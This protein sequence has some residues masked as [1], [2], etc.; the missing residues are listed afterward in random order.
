MLFLGL[1]VLLMALKLAEIGPVADWSWWWILL[2][3]GLAV[4]WWS[5]AD[6][7][8]LTRRREMDKMEQRKQDRRDRDMSALGL[9]PRCEKNAARAAKSA[10]RDAEK[11]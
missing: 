9:T 6:S 5:F 3:F 11:R 2:P 10:R 8:G 4:A 1:G 7:T